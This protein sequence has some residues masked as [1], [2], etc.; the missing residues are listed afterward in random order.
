[1]RIRNLT[2]EEIKKIKLEIFLKINAHVNMA[3]KFQA[4]VIKVN[5]AVSF[6]HTGL[7]SVFRSRRP[8]L[9]ITVGIVNVEEGVWIFYKIS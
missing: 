6:E 7:A 4:M 1:M 5:V 2:V 9:C 8:L 3:S